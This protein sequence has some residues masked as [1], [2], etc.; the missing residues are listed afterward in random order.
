MSQSGKN[1]WL[2]N[3]TAIAGQINGRRSGMPR[4]V[5]PRKDRL[6]DRYVRGDAKV[7]YADRTFAS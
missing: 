6:F 1:Y 4:L 7:W 2:L 5:F 3:V